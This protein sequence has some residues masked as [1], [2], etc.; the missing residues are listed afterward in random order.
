MT[1]EYVLR[2]L[3]LFF[4]VAFVAATV[5][6]FFPRLTGQDPILQKLAQLQI[7]GAGVSS[8]EID[9]L[10]ETYNAKFGLDR[11]LWRQYISYLGDT[12]RLD[13]GQSI[14]FFPTKV[15]KMLRDAIPWTVGLLATATV[16]SFVLGSLGG[17][18]LA[19]GKAPR[20]LHALFPV[21]FTFSAV[22]F[23]LMGVVLLYLFAF[24]TDWLPLFGGYGTNRIPEFTFGFWTNVLKHA[25]LPAAS[26]VLAQIG[27]WAL[28]MR[29][30]MVTMQGEDYMHQAEAK[31]LRGPRI[32][33]RYALRNAIL[34]QTTALA[35]TLGQVIS[36]AIL[37]EIV[38]SYPGV[39]T[40]LLNAVQG[41][42]YF[43][44]QG[45]IFTIIITVAFAMLIIDLAYPLLDPRINYRNE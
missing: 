31:G 29:S 6:F 20:F 44:L 10:I 1:V 38:F 16:M 41:F 35:V 23:Y 14:S 2:R 40:L 39:G 42:D 13:F 24:Q 36:G 28:G 9:G 21:F 8:E 5:N 45:V 27:F 4:A 7:Q 43:V 15:T 22:P 25:I 12:A 3:A 30:M 26:I 37:V 11:P 19:W 33:F 34:P 17:A 18:L 32:F